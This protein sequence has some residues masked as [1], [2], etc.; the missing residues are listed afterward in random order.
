MDFKNYKP[1]F[2]LLFVG[3]FLYILHKLIFFTFN[4]NG[5]ETDFQHSLEILYPFF[6]FCSLVIFIISIRISEK[7]L[8]NVG[9]SF[10]VSSSIKTVLCYL[11][12][13]PILN[14]P[15]EISKLEKIDFLILFCVFLA[16]ETY[17]VIRLL[18]KKL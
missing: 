17:F 6:I 16:I 2:S 13:R 8:D 5:I 18:N 4:L 15:N 7:N 14:I 11:L 12:V 1:I 9:M 3:V 10:M